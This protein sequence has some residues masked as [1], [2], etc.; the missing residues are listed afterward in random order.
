[1]PATVPASHLFAGRYQVLSELGGGEVAQTFKVRDVLSDRVLAL[2]TLREDAPRDA[3]H[4]LSREFYLLSGFTHPGIVTAHDFGATPE[5]RPYFT[6]EFFDG[7][8]LNVFFATGFHVGLVG[9]TLQLLQALDCIHAQC[10]IYCDL[11]P[12][13]LLVAERDGAP[14]AKL[15]DFGF[16]ERLSLSDAA[17][18]RGTLGYVAPEVLKGLDADARADLYSLGLVLYEVVTGQ[19]PAKEKDI[20]RWLRTQYYSELKAPREFD[21]DIPEV[22]ESV[23]LSLVRKEPGHRPRSAVEVI[24]VLSRPGDSQVSETGPRAY[25]GAPRLA[26]RDRELAALATMLGDASRGCARAVFVSGEPGVGKSRL[27]SEFKYAAEL[28]GATV[29]SFEPSTLGAGPRSLA[30]TAFG[31]LSTYRLADLAG[32]D[33]RSAADC[34]H[35]HGLFDAVARGLKELS[36]LPRVRHSLVLLVD[37]FEQYEA[38]SL[39]FLRYLA[40]SLG[41]ERLMLLVAGVNEKRFLDLAAELGR[42]DS[43]RH[44]PLGTLG[45]DAVA[46]LLD[47]MLGRMTDGEVLTEWLMRT[48]GGNPLLVIET[49]RSLVES[50]ILLTRRGRWALAADAMRAYHRPGSLAGIERRRLERLE[51]SEL[52]ILK[53]GATAAGPI[54]LG[55]LSA[56]LGLDE[57]IL[58]K[59]TTRLKS[60]GLLRSVPGVGD[61]SFVLTSKILAATVLERMSPEERREHDRRA[62]QAK[63][64]LYPGK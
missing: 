29:V 20:M 1:M 38:T 54:A 16:A 7:L 6:M 28:E 15:I 64:L 61:A 18:P 39:D 47:S 11:K 5:G 55:F 12:Q 2:K 3:R 31:H 42:A 9:V 27:L 41:G 14:R 21:R 53:V 57:R 46:A 56:A 13:N 40:F 45:R 52:A 30:R 49:V 34:D 44:L 10:L 48:L 51:E 23:I 32:A 36:S 37:D 19:G 63:G 43:F 59:A 22:F 4:L 62:A 17:T 58:F 25:L 24:E 8:P 26:G 33:E 35:G 50:N 60:L